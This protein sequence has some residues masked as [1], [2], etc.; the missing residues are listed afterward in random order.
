MLKKNKL[1]IS[2]VIL[3]ALHNDDI[4]TA[5]KFV[6]NLKKPLP[7]D[8]AAATLSTA[9]NNVVRNIFKNLNENNERVYEF[10]QELFQYLSKLDYFIEKSAVDEIKT[11]FAKYD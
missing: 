4:D 5:I 9:L 7:S 2:R 3:A 8:S 1:C 10:I 6:S 11:F